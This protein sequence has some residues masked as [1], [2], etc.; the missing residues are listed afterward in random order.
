M[1]AFLQ[2]L[3]QLGWTDGRN[4]QIEYRWGGGNADNIRK[5]AT[6]LAALAP[7]VILVTGTQCG[8]VVTGN[9]HRADRIHDRPRPGR[10]W[11]CR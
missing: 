7:D 6:E 11:L 1:T 9:P 4:V 8:P 3:Q 2:G 5:Y 10:L